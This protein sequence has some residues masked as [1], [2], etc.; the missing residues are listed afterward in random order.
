MCVCVHMISKCISTLNNCNYSQSKQQQLRVVARRNCRN[1]ENRTTN[2]AG[3]RNKKKEEYVHIHIH[4]CIT[5]KQ[6]PLN[7]ICINTDNFSYCTILIWFAL[8]AVAVYGGVR[9]SYP[10]NRRCGGGQQFS[11]SK[12]NTC[13]SLL[14]L[15]L[16]FSCVCVFYR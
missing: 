1:V 9:K 8:D 14:A 15:L 2:N 6:Q 5:T 7:T 10:R 3:S 4:I 11:W 12:F 13:T 16:L